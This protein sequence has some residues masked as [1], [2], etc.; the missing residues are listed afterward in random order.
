MTNNIVFHESKEF[1][2]IDYTGET[3]RDREFYK[4]TFTAC[5]FTDSD[6]RG[7]SFEECTF[8]ECN[9]SMTK[10]D[11]TSF[12]DIF[13]TGCKLLGID[14]SQCN[15]FMSSSTTAS[16]TTAPFSVQNSIKHIS[17]NAH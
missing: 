13:F 14:F 17:L 6:L 12:R 9:F 2:N 10:V 7:N 4:C 15:K 8:E 16:W 1:T 3:L 5:N 11:G